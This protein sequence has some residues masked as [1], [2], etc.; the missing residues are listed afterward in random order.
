M[1]SYTAKIYYLTSPEEE[2]KKKSPSPQHSK[3][4][5]PI[6][7]RIRDKKPFILIYSSTCRE[8]LGQFIEEKYCKIRYH[9]RGDYFT[10][11]INLP[12]LTTKWKTPSGNI[13]SNVS[14]SSIIPESSKRY[15]PFRWNTV[16]GWKTVVTIR[17]DTP[18]LTSRE[19]KIFNQILQEQY[20]GNPIYPIDWLS[21]ENQTLRMNGF[22]LPIHKIS[23]LF[24][25]W[26]YD[27]PLMKKGGTDF[28]EH[29]GELSSRNALRIRRKG[30]PT[31]F[32]MGFY[33]HALF[34]KN[35]LGPSW[36]GISHLVLTEKN[37]LF[38]VNGASSY[39]GKKIEI[40]ELRFF[41]NFLM[42]NR[43]LI[44]PKLIE[45][46][47]YHPSRNSNSNKID[48]FVYTYKLLRE[49]HKCTDKE[50]AKLYNLNYIVKRKE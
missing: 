40:T 33:F 29:Y 35:L 10:N 38:R 9:I 18:K 12:L 20:S 39:I 7:K 27:L 2:E 28:V 32:Q 46:F 50:F 30:H 23:A 15:T 24:W 19:E 1:P 37:P 11:K 17:T 25:T 44:L 36:P 4:Y 34:R 48:F 22:C 26:R 21:I 42:E 41:L 16:N 49:N 43:D 8:G 31:D 14:H 47:K 5:G 13:I 3:I 6:I 45:N